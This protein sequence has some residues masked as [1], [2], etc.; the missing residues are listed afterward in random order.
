MDSGNVVVHVMTEEA[1]GVWGLEELWL[2]V[3]RESKREK[4]LFDGEEGELVGQEEE[5][6]E[7]EIEEMT[8]AELEIVRER[9]GKRVYDE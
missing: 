6:E 8:E 7:G 9:E 2:G 3:G 1:R 5:V 4:R